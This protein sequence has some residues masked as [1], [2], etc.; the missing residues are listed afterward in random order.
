MSIDLFTAKVTLL[1][2]PAYGRTEVV[3]PVHLSTV[4]GQ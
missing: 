1:V 4:N 3:I 2:H